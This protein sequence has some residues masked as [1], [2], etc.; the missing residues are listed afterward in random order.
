MAC[1]RIIA[2]HVQSAD[3]LILGNE[4]QPLACA[5]QESIASSAVRAADKVQASLIIVYTQTGHTA[6][7]VS[8]YRCPRQL[9]ATAHACDLLHS[10]PPAFCQPQMRGLWHRQRSSVAGVAQGC[11]YP[12]C[13]LAAVSTGLARQHNCMLNCQTPDTEC[14]PMVQA[15]DAHPDAGSAAAE[16]QRADVA[17]DGALHR[18]A[19]PCRAWPAARAG[20]T[21]SLGSV[22]LCVADEHFLFM[23]GEAPVPCDQPPDCSRCWALLR[24]WKPALE[25]R[26]LRWAGIAVH[27]WRKCSPQ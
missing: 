5:L 19:V 11:W 20:C 7:L 15:A 27:N 23:V 4:R 8:K 13:A 1:M 26:T 17:A 21:L 2:V 22:A 24:I 14:I 6:S 3:G 16:E 12:C 9:N 25:P 18:S 10:S